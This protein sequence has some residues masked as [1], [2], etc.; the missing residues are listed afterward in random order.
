MESQYAMQQEG[1]AQG[2][3]LRD[4]STVTFVLQVV[5]VR[6]TLH[7]LLRY[8]PFYFI[9][10]IK[11]MYDSREGIFTFIILFCTFAHGNNVVKRLVPLLIPLYS[12]VHFHHL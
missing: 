10:L 4:F 7:L 2:S 6:A 12:F 5:D 1:L 3:V 11:Y 9:L 8:A